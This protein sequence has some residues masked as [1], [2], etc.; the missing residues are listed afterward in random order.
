[1][2]GITSNNI[3]HASPSG[4]EIIPQL[5]MSLPATA[6][7][8]IREFISSAPKYSFAELGPLQ[9]ASIEVEDIWLL[10]SKSNTLPTSLK[11][12]SKL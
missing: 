4:S 10:R 11:K 12:S 5:N 3:K 1:M 2:L 8:P 9:N 6:L 7:R